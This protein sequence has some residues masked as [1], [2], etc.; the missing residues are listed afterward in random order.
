MAKPQNAT[1]LLAFRVTPTERKAIEKAAR[2]RGVRLSDYLR[3]MTVPRAEL[4][5]HPAGDAY[6]D[7]ISLGSP[8]NQRKT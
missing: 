4:P 1:R 8:Y 7:G 2:Q 5:A 6:L 3:E